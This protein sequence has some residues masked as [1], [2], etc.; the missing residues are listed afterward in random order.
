L[1]VYALK[2][3]QLLLAQS[4]YYE[5]KEDVIFHLLN[6]TDKFNI[7]LSSAFVQVSGLIDEESGIWKELNRYVLNIE[8]DYPPQAALQMLNITGVPIHFLT[9]IMLIAKCV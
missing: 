1:Q 5:T 2:G 7:D 9:P 4:F 8:F 6:L 3:D